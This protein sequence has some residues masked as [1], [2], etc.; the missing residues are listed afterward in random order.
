MRNRLPNSSSHFISALLIFLSFAFTQAFAQVT[1]NSSSGLAATYTTLADAIVA[2]NA[3]TITAPVVITLTGNE[4]APAGGYSIT[5]LGGTATNTIT[6]Q[7]SSS[8]LT[9]YTPQVAGQKYDAIIKII[10]GDYITIQNFTMHENSGNTVS[11]VG[12]NTMTEFGVALFATTVTNGAQNNTIQ[13][14]T[15][16]LSSATAYQNAIGIFSTCASSSTNG[17]Q[18]ATSIA[19]TN[20]NN[21]FYG[22]TISGVAQGFYFIAPAQTATVFESGNDIGGSSGATGNTITFGISNTAG[23]LG[24]T[25]YSGTNPAGVYF[26]N[27]VGNS[28]KYNTISSVSTLSLPCGGIFSANGTS[29]SGITYTTTF[30]NNTITLTNVGIVAITGIDFG[31]GL[32][33]GTMVASTNNI[34]INQNVSAA[35]SA[36]IMGIKANYASATNTTSSNTI[37]INQTTTGTGI[38]NSALT[39]ISVAGTSTN[40]SSTLNNITFNQTTSSTAAVTG[41]VN[42]IMANAVGTVVNV[43]SNTITAK[44]AVSG[45]GSYGAGTV[46]YIAVGAASGTVNVISNLLLTT[47]S[48]IRSAGN[49]IGVD[50]TTGTISVRLTIDQNTINIDRVAAL[51]TITG[52]NESTAPSTVAHTITN[53]SVTFTNLAGSTVAN[54]IM[55]LGGVSATG[56]STTVNSNTVNIS[57]TNSG[58]AIGVQVGYSYGT[59]NANTVTINTASATL[60]GFQATGTNAGAYTITGNS[61]S[62]TSSA[63]SPTAMA[64]IN[65]G[66]T[67]PFQIYSNTF[68]ALNFTGILTGTPTVTA[69]AVATGTGNNIYNNTITNMT[70]GAATSSGSPLLRGI[71]IT[72]GTTTNVYKNKIYGLTTP[73][74][75]ATTLTS[76]IYISAGTTNTVYNNLIGDLTATSASSTDAVRG[77]NITST[78]A[79]STNKIYFNTINLN[80]SSTGANFGT[81]GI[82]HAASGT[83][84]TATLDMRNNIIV[85][86]SSAAGSGLTVAY[87][88]SSGALTMLANYASTSNFNLFYAGTPSA[89]NLIYSDGTSSA[90]TI[91]LYKAGAFTAGTI[92]PRDGSSFTE[93]APFLSTLGS[94][95]NFLHINP[96]IGTQIESGAQTIA[97]ILDDFDGDVRNVTTPDVGADEGN[98]TLTDLS[99]PIISYTNFSNTSSTSIY[100]VSVTSISDGSG[101]EVTP[102]VAPRIYYKRSGDAN[103]FNSNDNS[104]D[105]W[106]FVETSSSSSPY[107]FAIDFS[108]IYGGTVVPTDVIQYF[109]IAQDLAPTPN[110]SV[111][112]GTL[113]KAASTVDLTSG[114]FPLNG[115]PNSFNIVASISGTILV[116][117]GQ[118]YTTIGAAVTALSAADI[119]GPVILSLIDA[120]YSESVTIPVLS[121]SSAT[122]TVTIKP[123]AGNTVTWTSATAT[124][125]TLRLNGADYII[126][127]GSNNGTTSRNMT[128]SNTSVATFSIPVWIS[129]LGT[130]AGATYV[131]VK[132]C[133]LTGGST[134]LSTSYGVFVAGQ[135]L[136]ATGTGDDNDNVTIQ[137]NIITKVYT[138]I[139]AHATTTGTNNALTVSGNTIGSGTATDYI[140]KYGV[141]LTWTTGST[142][143]GNTIFSFLSASISY[144]TG[145]LLGSNVLNSTLNANKIYQLN[146]TGSGGLGA[147]GIHVNTTVAASN[148]T[149]SNSLIYNIIAD[150]DLSAE[151][152]LP[153]G[154]WLQTGGGIKLYYNSVNMYGT[155]TAGTYASLN[156]ALYISAGLT[157]LDIR[158]NI[159]ANSITKSSSANT[160]Y[161]IYCASANTAFTQIGN[162]IYF[163][164]GSQGVLGYL[165]GAQA[166]LAAWQTATGSRD[167]GS[168]ASDPTFR[169]NDDLQPFIGSPAL[170]AGT[171][172]SVT[173]DYLNV[174]RSGNTSIGAYEN[175]VAYVDITAPAITYTNLGNSSST[176]A[177]TLSNV[178]I[179]DASNINV[180]AGTAPRIY[181]KKSTNTDAFVGNTSG[182]NGWKYVESATGS[183]PFSFTLDL[184]KVFGGLVAGETVQYF[185]VAQ[186]LA[187]TPNVGINSGSFA[188]TPASVS[189]AA[190]Q[191]PIGGVVKTFTIVASISGT[192]LVGTGQTYT[193]IGAAVTALSAAEITGP[194]VLSLIDASYSESV[195]IPVLSGSSATNTVTIK[196]AASTTV[197]WTSASTTSGTLRLNGSDYIIVDGSNNGTTSRNMTISNTS[198]ATFSIPVWI[199]S[200]GTGAGATN[201]T[202]KN[203]N[204]T[205]GSTA[206]ATS[207]GVFIAGQTLSST[208][209]GD[210][211]D[212]V[213]IQNNVISKAYI[214]V[215]A[216]ASATGVNNSLVLRDNTIGSGTA[217]DYIGKYGLDL[218]YTTG[219]TVSGNTIY[220][221]IGTISNP[222][223]MFLGTSFLNSSVNANKIYQLSY[224][225]SSGYGAKGIDINTGNATSADTISN[226]LIYNLT[227]DGWSAL[228]GD[229][230]AGIRILGTTGGLKIWYNSVNLYGNISRSSAVADMSAALYVINTATNL[231]I[232]NNI[233]ANSIENTTGVATAYAIY[234]DAANTAFTQINNNIYYA[235]GV[236]GKLGYLGG[237]DKTTLADWQTATGQDGFSK[238]SNPNFRANDNLQPFVGSLA[239]NAGT[240][241]AVTKDYLG[242]TRSGNTSIGAYET[243]YTPPGVDWANLQWPA[244]MTLKEGNRGSVYAQVYKAGVTEPAGQ[245]AGI[246]VWIGYSSINSNPNTVADWKWVAATFSSQQGNNDEYVATLG[247][248][249]PAGTY[250]YASRFLLTDGVYQYGGY[251]GGFWNGAT[252]ASGVLTVEDAVITYA[253]V[254]FPATAS[255]SEGGSAT[256]YG[257]VYA[258][259]VTSVPGAS[260][261]TCQIGWSALNSNPDTWTNW[262]NATFNSQFGNNDEYMASLGSSLTTGTYYYA[263][264]Y[265]L[266]ADAYYY[267]GYSATGGGAWDGVANISGVL[268][269]NP[270]IVN[271]P[272]IQHFDG[273]TAPALPTGWTVSD[274]NADLTKWTNTASNPRTSPNAMKIGYTATAMDDW[275]FSPGVNMTAGVTYELTFYY[276]AESASYPEKLEVKYGTTASAAGMTSTA[277]FSNTSITNI[278]YTKATVTFTPATTGVFYLGWHGF[279]IAS[280]WN[281]Y[282]DDIM[283]RVNPSVINTQTIATGDLTLFS[284]T[285]TGAQVQFTTGN[286]GSISLLLEKIPG[287]PHG[288]LPGGL[289]NLANTY[290]TGTVTSGIV[291]GTYNITLDLT[292]I[293]GVVDPATIHLVKRTDANGAWTDVGV[294]NSISGLLLTWNGLTSFSDFGL[295]GLSDNPLPVELSNFTAKAKSRNANL[296]WET[297]TEVDNSGFEVQRKDKNGEWTKLAFVE[298]NGTSNSPKYYSFEDKKLASGMHT[299]RLKQI[300]NNGSTE[301]SDE[302]EVFIDLPAEFALSQNYPNPFNPSTKI[303]YQLASDSKVNIELYSITGERV[304]TLMSEE[305]QAGYYSMMIDAFKHQL[306]SGIYIY[307][308]IATDAAG[309]NFISTKKL[310]LMK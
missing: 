279:S 283:V 200:L 95:S 31:S 25:S 258:A 152:Y 272:Y 100:N 27:V 106:K 34:T 1:T 245:G 177:H 278:T 271:A 50:H 234:S 141:D 299:Y 305:Q 12:T 274:V 286:A 2:L 51:G 269:V 199:S 20:S 261:I 174:L 56:T 208:G 158:N 102:G 39:G 7:G 159:F 132:N 216:H 36:A 151:T 301:F 168:I 256:I 26:R 133:N 160:S 247:D 194:V 121:G 88:R 302:V 111:N 21:K 38:T 117:T 219:A 23:D 210:D 207:Y 66:A 294:A 114:E 67:G 250:Y 157:D 181:Y 212:N 82:Y 277:I 202:I 259:N 32:S 295:A 285:G 276:R 139:Y 227:G 187:P 251:N 16:T 122:N 104:T 176:T 4:T 240:P 193:T 48:T 10:G 239:L 92:A 167:V 110:V 306:A 226:N 281:L 155:I 59:M 24:F 147:R 41:S 96:A 113:N 47:G 196:P 257:R 3:A 154:I 161:A 275:F 101:V 30:S 213:T 214:G 182:D 81:T 143:S 80:A 123:A 198:A 9:A 17:V 204:L 180:T 37:V 228:V 307:R 231:D 150:G 64:A 35:V 310:V 79:L 107:A 128:I 188:L 53:N 221:F 72:G 65:V 298:G 192:I 260:G 97:G 304:A 222:A 149:I 224:T 297:K 232:R 57:G 173:R 62:L 93:N 11:A 190:A 77:I 303:D 264:R 215:Y 296:T 58:T 253:N 85:N 254:Q 89:S 284:F 233:F 46:N 63:I 236:E 135:T 197:V 28:V 125:G 229:A 112:S 44:Q 246:S 223:G 270:L 165:G 244:N 293:P 5:Q 15:I 76:G 242:V 146:Y 54:G 280:Q 49:C 73:A 40:N 130:G 70:V 119:T 172:V 109:V 300:D 166:T 265:K 195:T 255:I 137:N 268:T 87:R 171:P 225:G 45:S 144:P 162:N 291:T 263:F 145:I 205:G 201:V 42:G 218:T 29:P 71:S 127:D 262:S 86:K 309:K 220:N 267:G 191:S 282:V 164:T 105:G 292:G 134:T 124:S 116:G 136:S 308:M 8:T 138:G 94:S 6:I 140:G 75:G 60:T 211:N 266:A 14:N 98:F 185:V 69:I 99:G 90:Q 68:S 148:I 248:S 209:T 217:T 249:L 61:V 156:A 189:L 252:N 78:T 55:A 115:T 273:V 43:N 288:T 241:V 91:A 129:S 19:G 184:T 243:G 235:S 142:I 74:T 153:A 120:T 289:L 163:A 118:T 83:A 169:A 290:W 183:S 238:E 178:T 287:N 131:T 170:G 126:V 13:N 175:G 237:V 52:T 186:D 179:T 103:T 206:L 230:I 108:L 22:N 84:T 33:T 18:V 203:C